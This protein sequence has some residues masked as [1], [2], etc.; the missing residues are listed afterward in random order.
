VIAVTGRPA[1]LSQD[2]GK[3]VDHHTKT[4]PQTKVRLA[5]REGSFIRKGNG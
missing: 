5:R 2:Q 3:G 1:T 4:V